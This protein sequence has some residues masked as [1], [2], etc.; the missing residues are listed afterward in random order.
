MAQRAWGQ[1]SVELTVLAIV[2]VMALLG[3]QT[4]VRRGLQAKLKASTNDLL[5]S[6]IGLDAGGNRVADDGSGEPTQRRGAVVVGKPVQGTQLTCPDGTV[7]S[8]GVSC[9]KVEQSRNDT[10][11]YTATRGT[12]TKLTKETQKATSKSKQ[13]FRELLGQGP[14]GVQSRPEG[15][16]L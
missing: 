10:E 6:P 9:V 8:A 15:P 14:S 5:L 3:M 7:I 2:T 4:Y 13:T 16:Q 11:T 12:I 1:S